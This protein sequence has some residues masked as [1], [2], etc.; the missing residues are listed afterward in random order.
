MAAEGMSFKA[1]KRV[2]EREAIPTP[3][4]AEFWDRAFFR[5]CILDDNYRPHD[6]EEIAAAVS[7]EVVARLDPDQRYGL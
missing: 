5:R 1:I 2:F 4:G 3:Q 7:P 6:F